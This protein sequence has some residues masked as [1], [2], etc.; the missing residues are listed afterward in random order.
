MMRLERIFPTESRLTSQ[1]VCLNFIR[2]MGI[3]KDFPI[4]NFRPLTSIVATNL[5]VIPLDGI[6]NLGQVDLISIHK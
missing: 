4:A 1:S 2:V 5:L 3:S 6:S